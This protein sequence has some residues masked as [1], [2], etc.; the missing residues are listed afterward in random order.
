[1]FPTHRQ[2]LWQWLRLVR[3]VFS[4]PRQRS[5]EGHGHALLHLLR[6]HQD[7]PPPRHN[8]MS[9]SQDWARLHS[10]YIPVWQLGCDRGLIVI[11]SY[12]LF[13]HSKSIL[14]ATC[15]C[16]SDNIMLYRVAKKKTDFALINS[17]S[18]A[19]QKG[20]SS[21]VHQKHAFRDHHNRICIVWMPLKNRI[22]NVTG[23]KFTVL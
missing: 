14:L 10:N 18:A 21:C 6:N 22:L 8:G 16:Y 17:S 13:T 12:P 20:L 11:T 1:M 5:P 4:V 2:S 23:W 3:H 19:R 7:K 15:I 9:L